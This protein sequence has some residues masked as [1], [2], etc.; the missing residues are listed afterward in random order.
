MNTFASIFGGLGLFFVG[1]RL[2]SSHVGQ[3]AGRRMRMLMTRTLQDGRSVGFLG[4]A[5]GALLQS[6]NA[7]T[8]VLAALVAA[9]AI[10]HRRAFPVIGWA[11]LGTSTLVV[12]AAL[13]MHLAVL[14][15]IGVTGV[16][17]YLN[18]DQAPRYRH[19]IGALLGVGLLMLGIDFVKAG[20]SLLRQSDTLREMLKLASDLPWLGLGLGMVVAWVAQSSSTIA[21]VVMA[22]ASA[23]LLAFDAGAF[24]IVGA[25][26]GSAFSALTL[27]GRL[28]GSAR[29]LV[30]YQVALKG[31]GVAAALALLVSDALHGGRVLE[32]SLAASGLS[33]AGQL[34]AVFVWLQVASSLACVP[35]EGRSSRSSSVWLR[36]PT[37]NSW[38]VPASCA[39]ESWPS[40]KVRCSWWTR[41][42]S[43][44]CIRSRPTW[45]RCGP[46]RVRA[47]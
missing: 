40:R 5:A 45:L 46:R 1:I 9:G 24:S 14:M 8:F 20:S 12:L 29:Q 32:S 26:L 3:L 47:R 38:G 19:A 35:A 28:S 6:V 43:A 15:L 37:R 10:D 2:I 44:C 27:S 31:I 41:S 22:M 36:R 25:G 4:L 21:V 39:T 33:P 11:N 42:S 13:N 23:G 30:L 18:L 17:F 34:G 16:A 7:V